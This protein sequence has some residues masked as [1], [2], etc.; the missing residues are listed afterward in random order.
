MRRD[1]IES[2][3]PE[4]GDPAMAI[5]D[6]ET[7]LLIARV[8]AGDLRAREELLALH[9]H[10]LRRMVAVRLDDRLAA[11]VD[12]SDVVQDALLLASRRLDI[13]LRDR[14]LPFYP[15]LHRLATEQVVQVHRHHLGTQSRDVG[16]E[17][18]GRAISERATIGHLFEFLAASQTSPSQ[19][20]SRVEQKSRIH[21]SLA[22]L[23]ET[24]REILVMHY[25]E[26]LAFGEIAAVLG[27]TPGAA[28]VRH[29]RALERL[30]P[31][32]S[33]DGAGVGP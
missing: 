14:P 32:L 9:R 24:D 6:E 13:F 5:R 31:L 16:R 20:A 25:L 33:E 17:T 29:F 28:K 30:R 12:P 8:E 21:E 26:D 27:I 23:S 1:D 15:W 11:R 7:D 4:W 2:R 3:R 19:R 22:L 10:R 18:N